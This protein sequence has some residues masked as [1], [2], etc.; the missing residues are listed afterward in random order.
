MGAIPV[1]LGSWNS[2]KIR[3]ATAMVMVERLWPRASAIREIVIGLGGILLLSLAAQVQIPLQPVPITGQTFGVL[4]VGALLGARRGALTVAGYVTAGVAGLPVFA[5]G[6]AGL[7]RLFG[8]TGGY[9]IGFV[10]AAWLVGWL[11]ERGWDRRLTT[12]AAAMLL[13]TAVIYFF[14]LPWLS[15]FVGWRQVVALGLAPFIVGDVLKLALA[16]LALPGGW[17]LLGRRRD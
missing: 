3:E 2:L 7:A 8:P 5:G 16:A 14:G 11:S 10:A 17:S 4:L 12:A 6:A 15:I 13:G 9:L 1:A